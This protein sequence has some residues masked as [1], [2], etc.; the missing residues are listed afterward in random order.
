MIGKNDFERRRK[1]LAKKL[2]KEGILRSERCIN[3]F[4]RVPR[5]KFVWKGY[6]KDAYYDSPL[7]LGSTGQTISAPHMCAYLIEELE[8]KPGDVVLE[9]GGGSG[10]QAAL[11]AECV[12]PSDEDPSKWGHV[13]TIEINRELA[14]F[15]K[16][17]LE[18]T[19]Y[20]NRVDVI[21]G[22]GSLGYPPLEEK[23]RYDKILL[24]AA[25][26]KIPSP[27]IKQLKKGGILIAP[28]G[29]GFFQDLIKIIKTG[30]GD[31]EEKYLIKVAFVP[32]RGAYGWK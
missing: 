2:M 14:E 19:G 27:L 24:T 9:I 29:R 11:I 21:L 22:D 4:L 32:L 17:N 26:P 5:E 31:I 30:E 12:A 1:L 3:A 23:E 25:A 10:Y 28:V 13:Y 15:A 7:P 8:L 20:G 6:E 18:E 16:K